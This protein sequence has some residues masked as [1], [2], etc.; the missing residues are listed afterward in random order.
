[1]AI[2]VILLSFSVPLV[3]ALLA[4]RH[5]RGWI[6]LVIATGAAATGAWALWKGNQM[7]GWDGIGY[8]ILAMLICAPA[9]LGTGLG[10]AIGWWRRKKH[11]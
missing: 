11:R 1:M 7:Q 4:L 8:A 3:C 5:G 6:A 2:V 10:S 9:L